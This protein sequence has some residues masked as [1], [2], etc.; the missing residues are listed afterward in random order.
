MI[1][2]SVRI[3][4]LLGAAALSACSKEAPKADTTVAQAGVPAAGAATA[5]GYDPTSRVAT[6]VARDFAFDAPDSIPG[7]WV[8]LRLLN[9]GTTLHHGQL[10]RLDGGK[11]AADLEAALKTQGPPPAWIVD[12]C[13]P[14]APAPTKESKSTLNLQPG[15]YA[16][17]CFVDMPDHVPHF[18]KGM[19]RPI[20]VTAGT[21]GA[22]PASDV[23]VSLSD[24]SFTVQGAGL[25]SG[26]HT[27][28]LVNNGPQLHEIEIVRLA[29]GK[30]V[31][32]LGAWIQNPAGPPP[33]NAIG[34][35]AAV[36]K[37][38]D[39]YFTVDFTP[40]NYALLC[41]V[42]DAKDGKPHLEH[43]MVKEF[44]IQ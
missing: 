4:A 9:H 15:N 11:T 41:S 34:G 13:G 29:P 20:K 22:A 16:L 43:G 38:T 30:T 23:T 31:K 21:P 24:F 39:A 32:D 10:V 42:P 14:N 27:V 33:A 36:A 12:V 2:N 1:M 25:T 17:L 8:T 19:V 37:S 3:L 7:G 44:V 35:T 18:A 28:K 6:I 40:G 5:A 26:K